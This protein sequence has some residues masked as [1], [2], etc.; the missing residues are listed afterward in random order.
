MGFSRALIRVYVDGVNMLDIR[1][2][3]REV[4]T[5]LGI[6]KNAI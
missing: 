5:W 6:L 2:S 4:E 3:R 1:M